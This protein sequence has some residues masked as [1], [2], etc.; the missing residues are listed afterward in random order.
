MKRKRTPMSEQQVT[1]Y[2]PSETLMNQEFIAIAFLSQ[3]VNAS[4]NNKWQMKT[5]LIYRGIGNKN[6]KGYIMNL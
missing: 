5:F 4:L 1:D 6:F 3:H 2:F